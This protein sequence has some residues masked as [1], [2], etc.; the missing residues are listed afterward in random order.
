MTPADRPPPPTID[1]VVM[2]GGVPGPD[3]PLYPL[4]QGRPKALLEIGGRPMAQWVLD[5]LSAATTIR[6]VVIA[7]LAP[8]QALAL[9]CARPWGAVAD[10]GNLIDNLTAGAAWTLAQGAP[11]THVLAVSADIPLITGEMVD[12]NVRASLESDHDMYYSIIPAEVMER[13]FP[14]SR[15]TFFRLKEGRFTA[16]DLSL[17]RTEIFSG[18][19]PAWRQ[20]VDARKS[21]VKQAALVGWDTFLLVALGRLSLAWGQRRIRERLG[22]NGRVLISPYAEIGMDVDKPRQYELLRREL[23]RR[24]Q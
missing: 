16:G 1:A 7:G 6:R 14:G 22:M 5:A 24:P 15:R 19:H 9:S 12:W 23:E 20:I 13:R 17:I 11:P 18:Y 8:D 2:A 21:L 3:D 4:T 10:Q